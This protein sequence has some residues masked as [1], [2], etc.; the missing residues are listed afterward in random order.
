MGMT[1]TIFANSV[2]RKVGVCP[3]GYFVYWL[4][5]DV[6]HVCLFVCLS[7]LFVCIQKYIRTTNQ[8]N[9]VGQ[10]DHKIDCFVRHQD[11]DNQDNTHQCF[12][13]K[14]NSTV[15]MYASHWSYI[16]FAEPI[17]IPCMTLRAKSYIQLHV[18]CMYPPPV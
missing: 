17:T 1:S 14:S 4:R 15:Y 11:Q 3:T 12:P 2:L 18:N 13:T 10:P 7:R 16:T 6:C 8:N 5:C 9:P